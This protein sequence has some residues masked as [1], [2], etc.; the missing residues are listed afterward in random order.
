M[1]RARAVF[2]RWVMGGAVLVDPVDGDGMIRLDGTAA[3]L[4]ELVAGAADGIDE[5][6]L[7]ATLADAYDTTPEA[8][9]A[10]VKA[11]ID[12]LV[13]HTAVRRQ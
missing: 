5:A 1:I 12:Q 11:A 9:E 2:E 3:A 4:W 6:T 8:I 7:V 13:E 10:D